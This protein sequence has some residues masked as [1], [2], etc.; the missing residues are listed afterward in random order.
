VVSEGANSKA[1]FDAIFT[2]AVHAAPTERRINRLPR[3]SC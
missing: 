3:P 1:A 2:A